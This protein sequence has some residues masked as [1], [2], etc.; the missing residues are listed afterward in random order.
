VTVAD[1]DAA[2]PA[3][4]EAC[5]K[6]AAGAIQAALPARATPIEPVVL[7]PV[8]RERPGPREER[9]SPNWLVSLRELPLWAYLTIPAA[10]VFLLSLIIIGMLNAGGSA[11]VAGDPSGQTGIGPQDRL[12]PNLDLP[13]PKTPPPATTVPG[14]IAYWA[15]EEKTDAGSGWFTAR[16]TGP[17]TCPRGR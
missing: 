13:P 3:T 1:E 8:G 15:F 14:L 4:C 11:S 2:R 5:Q 10:T 9:P 6:A 7:P 12:P 16:R 17:P